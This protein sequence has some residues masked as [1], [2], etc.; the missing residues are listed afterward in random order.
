MVADPAARQL[1]HKSLLLVLPVALSASEIRCD[2]SKIKAQKSPFEFVLQKGRH[3]DYVQRY[4]WPTT[5]KGVQT[6]VVPD[7]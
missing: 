4:T 3:L 1:G 2:K 5:Y 7:L 6:V